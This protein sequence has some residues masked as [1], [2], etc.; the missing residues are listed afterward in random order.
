MKN[1]LR[2]ATNFLILLLLIPGFAANATT[3]YI[4]SSGNDAN[5]GTSTSTPWKTLNKLNSFFASLKPGDNVL[6]NRGNVF[7]GFITVKKSGTS[8]AP[9]TI[10]V[11]GTGANPV[12]NGFTT[13]STWTNLGNNIWESTGTVSSLSSCNMVVVNGVNYAMGR[14]PNTGYLT[15]QSHSGHTSITS[16]SLGATNWTGAEV[17][18]RKNRGVIDRSKIT[19]QSGTKLTYTSGT[20]DDAID[21]FGFFIQNDSRTL[22]KQNEWYYN[23]S[24][25]K[26][27]IYSTSTPSQV[28]VSGVDVL[29]TANDN[30]NYITFSN[31]NFQGSNTAAIKIT[32]A[33]NFKLT[34]CTINFSGT[35]AINSSTCANLTVQNC[36][37][38]NSNNN[39]VY[40]MGFEQSGKF[41]GPNALISHN[42]IKNTGIF[43]GMISKTT[44]RNGSAV[45]AEGTAAIV[46]YNS[47]INTGFNAISFDGNSTIIRN[48]F[49]NTFCLILDDG[50][51][52]YTWNGSSTPHVYTGRKIQNNIVINGV[53][54]TAGTSTP[55]K[56]YV[57]G[58]YMDNGAQQ[59]EIS[60]N[61]VANI[62]RYAIFL[63]NAHEMNIHNNTAYNAN[64]VLNFQQDDDKSRVQNN[65]IKNNIFVA[66][67]TSQL[68]NYYG[69]Y[70]TFPISSLGKADSNYYAR[71]MDDNLSIVLRITTGSLIQNLSQWQGYSKLDGHSKKSPKAISDTNDL[72][73]EYNETG[74]SKTIS[75]P[76]KY[77]DVR[78][79]TYNGSI[80][81]APY[82][83]AILIKNGAAT[84][85]LLPAVNPANTVN[86]LDYKYYEASSYTVVPVFSG[87][88]PAKSGT[89]S[90]ISISLANRAEH[91][92]FNFAGFIN[93]P[94][95]G[96]YTFYTNSDDGSKLYID[97][98]LVVNNDGL[99]SAAEKSGSIGL[100][101]GKHAISI[102]YFNQT[103][104]E[105][106][107][108]SYAGTGISKQAI[109]SSAFYRIQPGFAASVSAPVISENVTSA[110]V[111]VKAY[112]NPFSDHIEVS[113][114]GGL[115]GE[116][117]ILMVDVSGK[118]LWTKS[119]IK[120]A[121]TFQESINTSA[122]QRGIYFLRIIQ[123]NTSSV[124]K[125]VK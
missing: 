83:S 89:T 20:S 87:L 52:I 30:M 117:K 27:R 44:N 14:Y 104:G 15:F 65:T 1:N 75:L 53:G 123:N 8:S 124:I 95:D 23:S 74:S 120:N 39:A 106:L 36:T 66:K 110:Q 54:A 105:I 13:V 79:V 64:H 18:I 19:G 21:N 99:H 91:M 76:Y 51:G 43:A 88:T 90:N 63:H 108:A 26:L 122:L 4:S 6:L 85:S 58:I 24:T 22:D 82:S 33:S 71:P 2:A 34:G 116:Y 57:D 109:P 73:F 97:N 80:T 41:Y 77:I 38:S 61:S 48:N 32:N 50:G 11:Y 72:R 28:Q 47:I 55:V 5:N 98:V 115:A 10:G 69:N 107:T 67:A 81:L 78:N 56:V 9:I 35:D 70:I 114:S 100:K 93:V 3:Y 60:G 40:A 101:A 46:E 62:M 49:I 29:V 103:G 125:L 92:A 12:I 17:V 111:E 94:T 113:I 119:G 96:Q 121:G 118:V 16:S 25:R 31:V 7:T 84:L 42:T 45:R 59:V 112:P 102:G 37:I 68:T 86:G